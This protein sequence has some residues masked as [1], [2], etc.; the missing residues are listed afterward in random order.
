VL[1]VSSQPEE[2]EPGGTSKQDVGRTEARDDIARIDPTLVDTKILLC[3][4]VVV[5]SH[6]R[7]SGKRHKPECVSGRGAQWARPDAGLIM[8]DIFEA[9]PEMRHAADYGLGYWLLLAYRGL[10]G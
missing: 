8:A 9:L 2:V 4:C 5:E 6:S 7:A 1:V 10:I 3:L